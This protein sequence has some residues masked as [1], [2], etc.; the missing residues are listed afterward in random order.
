M[1]V[2][3][4]F[5]RPVQHDDSSEHVCAQHIHVQALSC[6]TFALWELPPSPFCTTGYCLTDDPCATCAATT[7]CTVNSWDASGGNGC[8]CVGGWRGDMCDQWMTPIRGV[9]PLQMC[10]ECMAS[11][12]CTAAEWSADTG[13]TCIEGWGGAAC[14]D[15]THSS[16]NPHITVGVAFRFNLD[17]SN[18][19]T[20]LREWGNGVQVSEFAFFTPSGEYLPGALVTNPGGDNADGEGCENAYNQVDNQTCQR[21]TCSASSSTGAADKWFV[22]TVSDLIFDFGEQVEIGSY[23]WM[24]AYDAAIGRDPIKW[25]L[26]RRES[27]ASQW[28]AVDATHATMGYATPTDRLMWVGP[29]AIPH[30]G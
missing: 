13:C 14:L 28:E 25:T 18:D 17:P 26:E 8:A 23:D 27:A 10:D 12:A 22:W 4:A 6:G 3:S 30:R 11:G 24:T 2:D 21:G 19:H 16:P 5:R 9:P 29:F 1:C 7:Q 15:W 20:G